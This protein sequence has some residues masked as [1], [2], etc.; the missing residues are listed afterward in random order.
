MGKINLQEMLSIALKNPKF[1]EMKKYECYNAISEIST[2]IDNLWI[3]SKF[4]AL[5]FYNDEKYLYSTA[6]CYLTSTQHSIKNGLKYFEENNIDYK[7]MSW[8]DDYNGLGFT[9]LELIDNGVKN[10]SFYNDC[11]NQ[12]TAFN[13]LL[14]HYNFDLPKWCIDRNGKYDI[15]CSFE[16]VEHEKEPIKYLDSIMDMVNDGGYLLF[17][18][19]FVG[20]RIYF[21]HY[22]NYIIDGHNVTQH[23]A[24]R[25]VMKYL[26]DNGFVQLKRCF[27]QKPYIFKKV[28]NKNEKKEE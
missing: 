21:G 20:E 7:N 2:D 15:V 9:T 14:N 25:R 19:T 23:Q 1:L 26:R 5:E 12:V 10:I 16:I 8:F 24:V 13:N 18:H 28:E 3:S 27:N 17:S 11:M 6:N 22:P 4:N